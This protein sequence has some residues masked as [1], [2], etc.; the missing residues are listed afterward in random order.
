MTAEENEQ[1]EADTMAELG[2][3]K[4]EVESMNVSYGDDEDDRNE[5]EEEEE[6]ESTHEEYDMHE[7]L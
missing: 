7:E 3:D 2:I 5:E 4:D 6:K 1:W